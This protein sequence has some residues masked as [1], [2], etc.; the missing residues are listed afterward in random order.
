MPWASFLLFV[1][2]FFTAIYRYFWEL[3]YLR[4]SFQLMLLGVF[5]I[6]LI[7][8]GQI[9]C[10]PKYFLALNSF[11]YLS[12]SVTP[13]MISLLGLMYLDIVSYVRYGFCWNTSSPWVC[14][15]LFRLWY[16]NNIFSCKKKCLVT[17]KLNV[18]SLAKVTL[19]LTAAKQFFVL[20]TE[21]L[22]CTSG[23]VKSKIL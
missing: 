17:Y 5:G 20:A 12:I 23:P 13:S 3:I 8:N 7:S 11:E 2:V 19:F 18:G 16:F 15:C 14:K 4:N 6:N 1:Y 9:Q 21:F 10:D 22:H